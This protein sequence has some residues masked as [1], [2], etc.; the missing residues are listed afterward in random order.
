[1]RIRAKIV[2][3]VLPLIITTLLLAGISSYAS[4]ANGITRLAREF[5]DFKAT[6]LRKYAEGQW[7]LLVEN[8][9]AGRQEYV[10]AT[11]QAVAAYARSVS[12]SATEVTAAF[13]A[14][15]NL[16]MQ[17][18]DLTVSADELEGVRRVV[19]SRTTDL[20]TDLRV[21]GEDRV[22]KGF[23]FEPF[24]WYVMITD[25]RDT[26][27]SDVNRITYQTGV[28]LGV[29]S[30][31]AI[32]MLVV[33]ARYLTGPLTRVVV[34]MR[35]IIT[36]NDLS[37]R[38]PVEYRDETGE[39]AHTFNIMV[40][41]LEKA[42]N[43]VKSYAFTAVLS[44]KRE[45]KIRNIFQR[46]VPKDVIETVFRNPEQM[47]VGQDRILA[48]LFS[49]IRGFTT[50][51]EGMR[52]DDLVNAL[53]R[54]FGVMV[55]IIM[56]RSGIVDKYIG[57][58]IMAFF[59]APVH[60]EDDPLQSVLTGLEMT[61]GL[62]SFNE[63]Q[64][65]LKQMEWK[66]GVGINYGAVTVGNIGTEKKMDY[67]VIGD[68]VNL[69]SRLEGLTKKY[70]EPMLVSESVQ[71]HRSVKDKVPCR[72]IDSVAVKGKKQGVKIFAPKDKL[73]D[74]EQKGWGIHHAAMD[75]YY[76]RRFDRAS[77]LFKEVQQYL[78]G[79][80]ASQVLAERCERYQVEPPP[81][82]WGGVEIMQEK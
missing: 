21:G 27:Y 8:G 68:M 19:A 3:V 40:G 46:Y 76:K 62:S 31:L 67:T 70:H 71:S 34:T 80:Y 50:I 10:E 65:E 12:R 54:Y 45:Q 64:R 29:S 81:A 32:V 38:V 23:F 33:F 53:N 59:G 7:R 11:K 26:F 1:M 69:A 22:A 61:R 4:A 58:A 56:N 49:D 63:K 30:I 74:A 20:Q 77:V 24:G 16:V 36:Y 52:P 55:D 73:S 25:E 6:E 79:D 15:G 18:A 51:S 66:I 2:L 43:K 75:A 14:A 72:L 82:D 42:Y 9:F 37:E 78:P 13:D 44:Q 48:V 5:L 17:T 60:H 57:D 28:I 35:D 39:L 41:E 47:L